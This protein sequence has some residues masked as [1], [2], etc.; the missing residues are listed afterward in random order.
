LNSSKSQKNSN[1]ADRPPGAAPNREGQAEVKGFDSPLTGSTEAVSA[2]GQASMRLV[3]TSLHASAT[4][5]AAVANAVLAA[6]EV[7][8]TTEAQKDATDDGDS[9]L[10]GVPGWAI[11]VK[12]HARA[13]RGDIAAWWRQAVEQTGAGDRPVLFY[14]Q[15]RD[16]WRAVW[17]LGLHAGADWSQ[18]ALTV[19]GGVEAWA[20]VARDG[21]AQASKPIHGK[22]SAL[23]ALE[24][25]T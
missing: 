11:E 18:Y 6:A 12:R 13:Q 8:P 9:D 14:R 4:Q 15:D 10:L 25:R 3:D 1:G 17:S 24:R 7:K 22:H 19:E 5:S 23:S 21:A 16:Q 2:K 20:V